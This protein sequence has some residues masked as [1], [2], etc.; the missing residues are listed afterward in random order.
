MAI[1]I[2]VDHCEESRGPVQGMAASAGLGLGAQTIKSKMG[3]GVKTGNVCHLRVQCQF[4]A[5]MC[6]DWS[7]QHA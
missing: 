3:E 2:T 6:A 5:G 1:Y 7:K 4:V